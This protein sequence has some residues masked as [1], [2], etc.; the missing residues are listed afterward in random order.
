MR[1][2]RARTGREQ[3]NWREILSYKKKF[4]NAQRCREFIL[5]TGMAKH[6]KMWKTA[7]NVRS[8]AMRPKAKRMFARF[9]E[10]SIH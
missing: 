8:S 6:R 1:E 2:V 4:Q 3:L 5:P 10:L 7:A 9:F